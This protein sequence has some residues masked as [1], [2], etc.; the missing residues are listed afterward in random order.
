VQWCHGSPGLVPLLVRAHATLCD[1]GRY[2]Q[3]AHKAAAAVWERGLLK[4]VRQEGSRG[5]RGGV[6]GGVKG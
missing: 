5:R 6:G 3:A 2:L 4:K 1:D